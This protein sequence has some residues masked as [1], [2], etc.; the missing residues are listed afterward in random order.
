MAKVRSE[1]G[2]GQVGDGVEIIENDLEMFLQL[3]FVIRF[4]LCLRTGQKCAHRI[5][6]Q[7]KRKIAAIT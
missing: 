5:V 7:M 1:T 3:A 2:D 4:Q 6:D